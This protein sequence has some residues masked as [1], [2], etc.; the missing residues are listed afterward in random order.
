VFVFSAVFALTAPRIPGRSY[1]VK[2]LL[3]GA[4]IWLLMM[5]V[6]MPL[7]GEGF[8][9]SHRGM[10]VAG[11]CLILNVVYGVILSVIYRWL[12]G[13]AADASAVKT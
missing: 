6:F 8:F 9:A 4:A 2:G 7:A 12:V 3:F 1:A 10:L 5:V 11:L 13:P